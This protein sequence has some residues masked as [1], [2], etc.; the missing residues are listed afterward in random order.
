MARLEAL[1]S[2][3]RQD[4]AN[5]RIRF[6]LCM[7]YAS[8]GDYAGALSELDE[9]IARHPNYATAYFQAGRVAENLDNTA[10]AR[11]YYT[12]GIE[13][14]QRAGDPHAASEMSA[15]LAELD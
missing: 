6:M 3:V 15:A 5:E 4:P 2:M 9:L 11:D 12:R 14:A 8:T 1:K 13:A 7:E 10:A